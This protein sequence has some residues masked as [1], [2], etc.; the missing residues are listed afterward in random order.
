VNDWKSRLQPFVDSKATLA[1]IERSANRNHWEFEIVPP[2]KDD[3]PGTKGIHFTEKRT[4]FQ[5]LFGAASFDPCIILDERDRAQSVT[6][7]V[8]AAAM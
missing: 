5:F 3:K 6:V 2:A 8:M 7:Q 4:V 1:E